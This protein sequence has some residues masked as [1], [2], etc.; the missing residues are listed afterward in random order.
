MHG[1][2]HPPPT[3][4]SLE[5][6]SVKQNNID[7]IDYHI[8]FSCVCQLL[9]LTFE[10]KRD[11]TPSQS[12]SLFIY[13]LKKAKIIDQCFTEKESRYGMLHSVLNSSKEKYLLW[14]HVNSLFACKDLGTT[15]QSTLY[16]QISIYLHCI[17]I[18]AFN[19]AACE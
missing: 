15:E 14:E 10:S 3:T 8:Q 6:K 13:T 5:K 18:L 7:H 11:V 19:F 2:L 16:L 9:L 17:N 12:S 4:S 1:H